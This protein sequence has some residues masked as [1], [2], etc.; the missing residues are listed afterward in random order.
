MLRNWMS[1]ECQYPLK[2][3]PLQTDEESRMQRG[4]FN[5]L[6]H[7]TMTGNFNGLHL[8]L[9]KPKEEGICILKFPRTTL[10]TRETKQDICLKSQNK[11]TAELGPKSAGAGSTSHVLSAVSPFG[12]TLASS[13]VLHISSS[14][15][16][17]G[18]CISQDPWYDGSPRL[19]NSTAVA[20]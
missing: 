16:W 9:Q 17:G 7:N 8:T 15:I 5:P 3:H 1:H 19:K 10:R 11:D 6:S 13:P 4:D 12:I 14:G 18:P 2:G 20:T